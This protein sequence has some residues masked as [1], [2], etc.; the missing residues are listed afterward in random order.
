MNDP[1]K[2][3]LIG[4]AIAVGSAT[5]SGVIVGWSVSQAAPAR[6][7]STQPSAFPSSLPTGPVTHLKLPA[8][9]AASILPPGQITLPP[10][11]TT[12]LSNLVVRPSST[13]FP[14]PAAFQKAQ[15]LPEVKA[16]RD[17][18]MEAQKRY[19]EVVKKAMNGGKLSAIS[20][21]RSV[22]SGQKTEASGQPS[23]VIGQTK[24]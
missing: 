24:K 16:A 20:G 8:Q 3:M 19:S 6:R 7:M 17:A 9:A 13:S 10:A 1:I 11:A 2:Y 12:N 18:F 21:Q 4:A 23:A 15:E 22:G 5:L 14:P